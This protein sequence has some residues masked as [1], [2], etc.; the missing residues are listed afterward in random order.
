MPRK[1]NLIFPFCI[2]CLLLILFSDLPFFWYVK[3][4]GL[5]QSIYYKIADF[6]ENSIPLL[7]LPAS[8]AAFSLLKLHRLGNKTKLVLYSLYGLVSTF[9]FFRLVTAFGGQLSAE[10]MT[11][12]SLFLSRFYLRFYTVSL[13]TLFVWPF[14]ADVADL[15]KRRNQRTFKQ[16]LIDLGIGVLSLFLT[17]IAVG[18][19]TSA[20]GEVLNRL[21]LPNKIEETL[22]KLENYTGQQIVVTDHPEPL[23]NCYLK[24]YPSDFSVRLNNLI[25]GT[26][27]ANNLEYNAYYLNDYCLV[28]YF[29]APLTLENN[30]VTKSTALLSELLIRLTFG[31]QIKVNANKHPAQTIKTKEEALLTPGSNRGSYNSETNTIEIQKGYGT[32]FETITH[33]L[34]HSF[35][36]PH[37]SWLGYKYA[38]LSE[39]ITQYLT[40]KI[41]KRF[42]QAYSPR[43]YE[44]QV[45]ALEKLLKFIDENKLINIY[46]NGNLRSLQKDVDNKTYPGAFCRFNNYLDKS[47]DEHIDTRNFDKSKEYTAKAEKALEVKEDDGLGCF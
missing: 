12:T 3:T 44:E 41:L 28:I 26:S 17:L 47:L 5:R 14:L 2:L 33:E 1:P 38:G 29:G 40:G 32:I 6:L 36:V 15:V 4:F 7:A 46:F 13:G 25:A 30:E 22:P 10:Y 45:V 31:D 37:E 20:M 8:Y 9:F 42:S 35:A 24:Q 43:F 39:A 18:I 19:S 11:W 34:L 23:L 21:L 16:L 27:F